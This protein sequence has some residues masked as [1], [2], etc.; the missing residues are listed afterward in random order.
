MSKENENV[1]KLIW[2]VEEDPEWRSKGFKQ[3]S[4][5]LGRISKK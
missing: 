5:E 3:W 2:D 4:L 1:F